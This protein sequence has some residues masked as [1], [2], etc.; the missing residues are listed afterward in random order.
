MTPTSADR[1]LGAA[2]VAMAILSTLG[3]YGWD[4]PAREHGALHGKQL[5]TARLLALVASLVQPLDRALPLYPAR[6]DASACGDEYINLHICRAM[7]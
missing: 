7:A 6:W 4:G 3:P 5:L 1:P 2:A